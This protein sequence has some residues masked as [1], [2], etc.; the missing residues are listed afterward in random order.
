MPGDA[1]AAT[2]RNPVEAWR[3]NPPSPASGHANPQAWSNHIANTS[4]TRHDHA[5]SPAT[6][7]ASPDTLSSSPGGASS[8]GSPSAQR[9]LAAKP[10]VFAASP[11]G[12]DREGVHEKGVL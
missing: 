12:P 6:N 7:Q 3:T 4:W 1:C 11:E 9:R 5:L 2:H 10:R 8:S